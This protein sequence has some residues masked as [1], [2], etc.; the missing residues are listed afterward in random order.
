MQL[1]AL[2]GYKV[3][4]TASP[5]NHATLLSLGAS[6]C[7]NYRD[8]DVVEQIKLAAGKEGVFAAIDTACEKGS[9]D[10]CVGEYPDLLNI[11][12]WRLLC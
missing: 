9:T 12:S 3:L 11:G 4:T 2:S 5:A 8:T 6:A 1:A 10:H 7:F